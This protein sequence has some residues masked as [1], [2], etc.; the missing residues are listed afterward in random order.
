MSTSFYLDMA[1]ALY[2][3]RHACRRADPAMDRP[4]DLI[5]L[6]VD[7]HVMRS[8]R[9]SMPPQYADTRCCYDPY[10]IELQGFRLVERPPR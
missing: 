6:R 5:E 10:T 2:R 4:G 1:E 8:L 3:L 9:A 7:P